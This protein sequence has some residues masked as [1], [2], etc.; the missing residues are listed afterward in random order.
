MPVEADSSPLIA[1]L[2]DSACYPHPVDRIAVLETHISWV[3]LTGR[4][5][6]KIKKP[7]NLGFLDFS[8]LE[9]RRHYCGE[10]LRLNRRFAPSIYEAVVTIIGS[11]HKPCIGGHGTIIEYAVRMRE[12]AQGAL[13]SQLLTDGVITGAHIDALAARVA[14]LHADS[15][16]V[17]RDNAFGSPEAVIAPAL[18]NFMHPG[19]LQTGVANQA[20]ISE[21]RAWTEQ[22]CSAQRAQFIAR[23]AAGCVRECHGDLH[24]GN[25]AMLDGRL[26]PFD[27]IEFNPALRWIDVMSEVA[28]LVM[29]LTDRGRA[30]FATRFLN[31]YLEASGDYAGLSVLRFYLVYRAMV[32]AKVHALRAAQHATADAEHARLIAASSGYIGLAQ[33]L[34]HDKCP[35]IILM[36]GM[37]GSG[38]SGIAQ[39]LAEHSGAIHLRSD[40]ERKRLSGLA[41]LSRSASTLDSGIYTADLT[42]AT[43]N[44]LLEITCTAARAGYTAIVDATFLKGWQRDLFRRQA[45]ARCIPFVIVDVTAPEAVLRKRIATRL[46]A[47]SDAS[48]ADQAVLTRQLTLSEALTREESSA[49]LH[50]D[51]TRSDKETTRREASVALR[52]LLNTERVVAPPI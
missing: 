43:Y 34:A 30:D 9:A 8:T 35:A 26:T 17:A 22:E 21:L 46:A 12:F 37:S 52:T 32:R 25:I 44:R 15:D 48:E 11:V 38:K 36:H 41:P 39:G 5:A 1:A 19:R 28:F 42:R 10:E 51:T 47:R 3:I 49:V 33:Q 23:E 18:D 31:A 16:V 4:Y 24:L 2:C 7:L 14:A 6:Y 27:C 40:I 29:D 13:A 50:I 20:R 45:H